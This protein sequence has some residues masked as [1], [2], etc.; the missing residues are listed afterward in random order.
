MD[1]IHIPSFGQQCYVHVSGDT[2]S[3]YIF[4]STQASEVTKYV[5]THRLAAFA[6]M[7]KPQQFKTDNG[8]EYTSTAFQQ[9]CEAYQIHHITSMPYNPQGQ[10]I[11]EHAHTTLKMQLKKLK[12]GG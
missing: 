1:V 11:V 2:Y 6:S 10:A 5:I 7:G 4:A 9:F 3:G 8:P 12:V